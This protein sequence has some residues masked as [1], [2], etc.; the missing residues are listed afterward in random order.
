MKRVIPQPKGFDIGNGRTR[1]AVA[2]PH[3][4]FKQICELATKDGKTFSETAELLLKTGL[5]DIQESDRLEPKV[6]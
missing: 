2:M 3:E 5:C 1:I 4:L 6:A